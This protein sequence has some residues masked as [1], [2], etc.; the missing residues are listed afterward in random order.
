MLVVHGCSVPSVVQCVQGPVTCG[1]FF[2]FMADS[3]SDFCLCLY[4]AQ[5][6]YQG[7]ILKSLKQQDDMDVW[8][9][10]DFHFHHLN[11]VGHVEARQTAAF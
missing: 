1:D 7:T 5:A 6:P 8:H 9:A 4:K 2:F 3:I 11:S 10:S